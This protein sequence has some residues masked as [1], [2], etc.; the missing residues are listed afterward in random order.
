MLLKLPYPLTGSV[1]ECSTME[2][3]TSKTRLDVLWYISAGMWTITLCRNL[4]GHIEGWV[5][6]IQF[7]N[8]VLCLINGIKHSRNY[9]KRHGENDTEVKEPEVRWYTLWFVFVIVW[10][11]VLFKEFIE[12]SYNPAPYWVFA[13]EFLFIAFCIFIGIK[14]GR[15]YEKRHSEDGMEQ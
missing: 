2:K 10:V 13:I 5:L 7:L 3:K 15:D 8:I 14:Q 1:K 6:V 9:E 12:Y 11:I 4:S